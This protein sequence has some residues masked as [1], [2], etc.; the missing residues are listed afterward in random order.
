MPVENTVFFSQAL[1]ETRMDGMIM[2]PKMPDAFVSRMKHQLGN[3]LPA[4]LDALEEKPIR[5]IRLNTLKPAEETELYR[6]GSRPP[7]K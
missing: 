3:E 5:G 2:N 6:Q 7:N 4:F 1:Y